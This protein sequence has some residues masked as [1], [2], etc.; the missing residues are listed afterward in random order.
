MFELFFFFSLPCSA[1]RCACSTRAQWLVSAS[2]LPQGC[3]KPMR[4]RGGPAGR[5][6]SGS[7]GVVGQEKAYNMCR[8]AAG[9]VVLTVQLGV[10]L[11]GNGT[12]VSVARTVWCVRKPQFSLAETRVASN[13][14]S[15]AL[16][17]VT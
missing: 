10:S 1:F 14:W 7:R 4:V 16:F 8:C 15:A 13:A 6:S 12:W 5:G 11:A 2:K 17:F 9:D 3:P